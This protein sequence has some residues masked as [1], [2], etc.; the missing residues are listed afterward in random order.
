[1]VYK[2]QYFDLVELVC[3]HVYYKY[4]EW[5]WQFIDERLLKTLDFI[6]SKNGPVFVN[7][8]D[9]P[10][11]VNSDYIL[12][13]RGRM[14]NNLPIIPEHVP[15]PPKGLLDERGVRCNL[16]DTVIKKSGSLYM[17]AHVHWTAVD[18]DVQG[19]IAEEVR[20]WI[21]N[22]AAKM[23]YPVRLEK[24]VSWVHLDMVNS[25]TKVQLINP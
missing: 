23:P 17:S 25:E 14:R 5:L 9:M 19:K 21:I 1:M 13:I 18:F 12:Y 15:L 11:Y 3:P 7:N 8:Y 10:Q 6:R 2:S 16:C 22:N 24:G 20:Q 4:G